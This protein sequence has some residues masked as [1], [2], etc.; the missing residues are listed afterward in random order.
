MPD[1]GT[2]K[3]ELRAGYK[4]DRESCDLQAL[5]SEDSRI[6]QSV[7]G[8]PRYR[9]ASLLLTYVSHGREVDT[10]QII[11]HALENGKTVACPRCCTADRSMTFHRI[12]SLKDLRTGAYGIPEPHS[13][14]PQVLAQELTDSVCLVPG[15]A[16]DASGARLGYGGGYYDRF[17]AQYRGV[18]F[19]LCR[20]VAFSD[21]PLPQDEYDVSVDLVITGDS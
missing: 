13:D 5:C 15:L 7:I 12:F 1:I 21:I 19:G 14:A 9:N 10:R 16:F 11:A 18:S 3:R 6:A 4:A 20:A 8:N 2:R 17:L